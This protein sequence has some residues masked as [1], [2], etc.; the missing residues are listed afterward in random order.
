LIAPLAV[1]AGDARASVTGTVEVQG[2]ST[3][4]QSQ[5]GGP[6]TQTAILM[7]TLTL[8]YAGMPLGA[9]VAVATAGGGVS[10]V[11]GWSDGSRQFDARVY[12]FDGSLGLL[13]RRALPLRLY[14]SGSV[15]DGSPG[16][17]NAAGA[18]PSLLYG[19]TLNSEPGRFLPG[20]RLDASEARS[21][22]PGHPTMS[23]L[24][25]RLVASGFGGL[26]G[27][28]VDVAVRT[29]RE[30]R[31][32]AGELG[33]RA[34]TLSI[35]SPFHQTNVLATDVHRSF[36]SLS[37]ITD[38][39]TASAT[40]NQRWSS[41]LS[42]QLGGRLVEASAAAATGTFGDAS[43]SATWIPVQDRQQVTLSGSANAGFTRTS[44]P[45]QRTDGST[46]GAA[47]RAGWS[48]PVGPL[49]LGLGAGAAMNNCD[50]AAAA[51]GTAT[52]IDGSASV[53]L[54][55][56]RG[57]SAQADYTL[58]SASAPL[59]RGG[60]RLE[61]H[62]RAFGRVPIGAASHLNGSL[63]YDDAVRE[64]VDITSGRS[65]AVRERA[66]AASVGAATRLGPAALW[67]ELR[68]TRGR[69]VTE[70]GSP[71]VV[72]NALSIPAVTT[73]QGNF[74]WSPRYAFLLQGQLIG[75]L[76]ELD[77]RPDTTSIGANASLTWRLGR[78]SVSLNYQ[79]FRVDVGAANPTLQQ[80]VRGVL[81]RP[82]EL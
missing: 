63:A 78:I 14:A 75:T 28:R 8:H 40:S 72:G 70:A 12:S 65:A 34:A 16:L 74:S 24:Q 49:T 3:A 19:G 51:S 35:S 38:D 67:A 6:G 1:L 58:V 29:E 11:R 20:L 13:P 4:S 27:Q 59:A 39:R 57:L 52:Q 45:G 54:L 36:A 18:G 76:T 82:F 7:E 31:D 25:Q 79:T 80:S 21:S 33:T 23:D 66:V 42:T 47:A 71:F 9:A 17:L 73:A 46:S 43:A 2:Q 32:G 37:G 77:G 64:L 61:N 10:N 62:A 69:V 60:D 55:P 15:P 81:S 26:A 53:A 44:A 30:S 41:R 22:R 5:A 68:H 50:C 48:R 56:S